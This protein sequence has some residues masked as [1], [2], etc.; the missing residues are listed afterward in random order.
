MVVIQPLM[1]KKIITLCNY[2]LL[3]VFA[4]SLPAE[5]ADIRDYLFALLLTSR[6]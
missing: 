1:F 3:R 5:V 2:P 6:R 4:M